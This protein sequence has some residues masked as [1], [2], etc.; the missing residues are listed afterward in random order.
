MIAYSDEGHKQYHLQCLPF[1][2]SIHNPIKS[3]EATRSSEATVEAYILEV[4]HRFTC[5]V[6]I[7]IFEADP[8]DPPSQSG[9]S[10]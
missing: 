3:P 4:V 5:F 7:S 1:F 6:V 2:L 10:V 9:G 8:L